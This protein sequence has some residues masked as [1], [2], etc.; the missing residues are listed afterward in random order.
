MSS[1]ADYTDAFILPLVGL[2]TEALV[3]DKS[4]RIRSVEIATSLLCVLSY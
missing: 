1:A 2:L 4:C 3:T